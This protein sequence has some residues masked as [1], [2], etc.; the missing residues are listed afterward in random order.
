MVIAVIVV[1]GVIGYEMFK[2]KMQAAY[3]NRRMMA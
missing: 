2:R 1:I 3:K